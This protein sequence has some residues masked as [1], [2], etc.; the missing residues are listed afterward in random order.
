MGYIDAGKAAGATVH[1]GG[2]RWGSEG[3]FIEPTIFTDNTPDMKIVR[4]E[5]FGPVA[6]VM[7]FEHDEDVIAQANDTVYG[8]AAAVFTKNID[9]A[10][11]TA[12]KLRAGSL[13]VRVSVPVSGWPARWLAA[14]CVR[15]LW[16][17]DAALRR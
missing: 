4:E 3:Y 15:R 6:V 16:N 7:K 1:L 2:A 10:L 9:R 5:I 13:W 14:S 12:Q 11:T 17:A 8:L